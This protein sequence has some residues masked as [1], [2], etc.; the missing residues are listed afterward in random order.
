MLASPP[1]VSAG[2]V[3]GQAPD[4]AAS[5]PDGALDH[6][7]EDPVLGLRRREGAKVVL[8]EQQVCRFGEPLLLERTRIPPAPL[9][10]KRRGRPA[11]VEAVAV[12]ARLRGPP[13]VKVGRDPFHG[14]DG[15][16]T[17]QLRIQRLRCALAW[18]TAVDLD[19]RDLAQRVDAGIGAS[20]DSQSAP[21]PKNAVEG[22]AK[23]VFDRPQPRLCRPA[24][25]A[26]AVVL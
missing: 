26:G 14:G 8:A 13:R 9:R 19:A 25:K 2:P 7:N 23:G 18:R 10:L 17:R 4:L 5:V 1:P 11:A 6:A 21:A 24:A 16:V 3:R 12:T 22:V 15:D 20:G